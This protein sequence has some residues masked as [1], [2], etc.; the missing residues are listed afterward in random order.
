MSDGLDPRHGPY[1]GQQ[2]IDLDEWAHELT[3]SLIKMGVVPGNMP[4]T[5]VT[6]EIKGFAE[7]VVRATRDGHFTE[8]T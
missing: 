7:Q 5:R 8:V 1:R 4:V 6:G 3:Y 2:K